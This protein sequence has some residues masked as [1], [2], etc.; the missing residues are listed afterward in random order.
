MQPAP[1]KKTESAVETLPWHPNFRNY[2]RLPDIKVVRTSFFINAT[3]IVVALSLAGWVGSRVYTHS[4]LVRQTE[5]TV[6]RIQEKS[7]ASN[8]A[9]K[10]YKDFQTEERRF[11][12]IKGFVDS[13]HKLSPLLLHLGETLPRAVAFNYFEMRNDGMLILRGV[14]RGNADISTQRISAYEAQLKKDEFLKKLDA[15]VTL[16]GANCSAT[17]EKLNFEIQIKIKAPSK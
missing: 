14:V 9:I 6:A 15:V 4:T 16:T 17:D 7:R 2:E 8:E 1:T 11:K 12:E 3:A 5:E 13:R 10:L